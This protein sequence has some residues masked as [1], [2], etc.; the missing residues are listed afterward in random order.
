MTDYL[1]KHHSSLSA[2]NS[3]DFLGKKTN[4]LF[5]DTLFR[6]WVYRQGTYK[7]SMLK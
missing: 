7:K 3:V 1:K 2:S 6:R 5:S 4:E